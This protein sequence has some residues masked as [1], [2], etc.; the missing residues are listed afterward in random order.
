M[1]IHDLL[2]A[3]C[4]ALS[5]VHSLG[6]GVLLQEASELWVTFW[7]K[8]VLHR[9]YLLNRAKSKVRNLAKLGSVLVHGFLVDFNLSYQRAVLTNIGE[10]KRR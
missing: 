10:I 1:K 9:E 2:H 4:T 7:V 5:V 8:V 6:D 3:V